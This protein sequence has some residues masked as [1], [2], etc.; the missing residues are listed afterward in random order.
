M[1]LTVPLLLAVMDYAFH[2][3]TRGI[4]GRKMSGFRLKTAPTSHLAHG[5]LVQTPIDQLNLHTDKTSLKADR[6]DWGGSP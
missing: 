6:E 1:L 3:Q 2:Y 5:S 4:V